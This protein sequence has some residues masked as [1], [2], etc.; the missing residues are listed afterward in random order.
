MKQ[1]VIVIHGA[2]SYA[3]YD[4]Y[5]AGLEAR[6]IYSL[7]DLKRKDWKA[8]LQQSLGESYDVLLPTMPNKNN[9]RY[10]EWKIWFEKI[11]PFVE[12]GAT[13]IG[14]SMGGIFLAKY[15]S[16]EKYMRHITAIILVAAPFTDSEGES[17][18]DFNFVTDCVALSSAT[19]NVILY[20]SKDDPVVPFSHAEMY[21]RLLPA[22]AFHIFEDRQHFNQEEL[23]E[24]VEEIKSLSL[25]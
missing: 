21:K 15:F 2:D 24:I 16:E 5:I 19:K 23:R 8:G 4:E 18:E 6:T 20:H 12:D 9:A 17:L 13:F 14:H 3:T 7:D 11:L 22:S 1:Q 10:K 25:A